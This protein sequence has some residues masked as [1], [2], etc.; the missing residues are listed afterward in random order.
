MKVAFVDFWPNFELENNYFF[1]LLKDAVDLEINQV[2][3]E[4]MFLHTDSYRWKERWFYKDHPAKRVF[5]TM[6][7][8]PPLFDADT[9]P[10]NPSVMTRG[11]V[12]FGDPDSAA[13]RATNT[14]DRDYYYGRCDF[15]LT[16]EVMDD[17]R[18]YRFPYWVYH[19]D[20]FNKGDYGG[21]PN[22]L[23][24]ENEI[25]N[26]VYYN[27]P[28]TKF[29]AIMVSNPTCQRIETYKK[30][31][32]YK[33]VDGY[34]NC[35]KR[36]DVSMNDFHGVNG[37]WEKTKLETLKDYRFSICFEHKVRDGYHSEKLFHAKVAGTIPIYWGAS[38]VSEDF[39]P[40]C[41]INL[42]DFES[43]DAMVERIK[44]IDQ[45]ETLYKQYAEAPLFVDGVIPDKFKPEAVL[46]FFKETVLKE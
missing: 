6:E 17:S 19:I 38:T 7:G 43:I 15:A 10:P 23:I 39:N 14:S 22:F 4:L 9:Y 18:H 2:D 25:G 3:P 31:S 16:H 44:E 5:W 26:N 32:K 42:N 27:A 29:C 24:P 36:N 37:P 45:N 30:L 1:H 28:K 21:E 46:N 20:W 11:G 35:F 13:T 12:G 34:G 33:Q 41:F 40:D 8:Q